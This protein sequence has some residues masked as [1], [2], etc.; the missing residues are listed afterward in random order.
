MNYEPV[1]GTIPH[2]VLAWLRSMDKVRHGYEPSTAEICEQLDLETA[3]FSNFMLRCRENGLTHARRD[4]R[5]LRWKLGDGM[6]DP[7]LYYRGTD[8]APAYIESKPAKVSKAAVP[9]EFRVLLFEGKL[10]TAGMEI[11]DGVAIYE[12]EMLRE[13]KRHTDWARAM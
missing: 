2:R 10:L 8:E 4:G 13:L 3:G 11:R 5:S 6:C 12:P 9:K 1:A 7:D